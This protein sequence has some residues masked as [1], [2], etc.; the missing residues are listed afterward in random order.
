MAIGKYW[1]GF[2]AGAVIGA[3]AAT[4]ALLFTN[5]WGRAGRSRIIRLQKS[6]Q[7]G[8]PVE[9]VFQAWQDLQELP[10]KLPH[11]LRVE[12]YG[13]RSRWRV[14]VNGRDLLWQA[15]IE[16]VVPNQAIGWKSVRGLKHTGRIIFS[17]LGNDTVVHITMNYAPRFRI[18]RPFLAPAIGNLEGL[19]EAVLRDFKRALETGESESSGA[20]HRA[21]PAG[22]ANEPPRAT[23]T[24][25]GVSR[26]P[27]QTSHVPSSETPTA[28][29]FTVPPEAKR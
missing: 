12:R 22:T 18:L 3:G 17:P 16:Q 27:A 8:R 14:R 6:I 1:N 21:F 23:G 25:G 19:I 24:L 29:K 5:L 26:N 20:G 15:Q 9:E 4:G 13:D 10:A 7:I 28:P 11:T 2:T